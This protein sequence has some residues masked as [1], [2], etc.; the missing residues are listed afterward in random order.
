MLYD[1]ILKKKLI[2]KLR[3]KFETSSKI[4]KLL[5]SISSKVLNIKFIKFE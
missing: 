5:L 3:N 4:F 2:N 1:N